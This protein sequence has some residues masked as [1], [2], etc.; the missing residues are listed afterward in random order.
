M[1]DKN[2]NEW[3]FSDIDDLIDC[4]YSDESE[5]ETRMTDNEI[6]KALECCTT[7]G[8]KCSD[9]PAFKK[10]DRSDCKK[11]FRGAI[12]IINRQQEDIDE[13]K[14]ER[15]VFIEDIHCSA[16]KINEQLE[17]IERLNNNISAMVV[18]LRNSAKATR[19]EAIKEFAERLKL[20][21]FNNGYESPDVDFDYFID[22]IVKEFV[23][24]E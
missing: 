15:E 17:E 11:Y 10:V 2:F 23:G 8:A 19:N 5:A 14:H 13:L 6:I 16:D 18:T 7:K 20:S 24:K 21:F 22:N 1:S 12:D 9:C 4:D 3:L